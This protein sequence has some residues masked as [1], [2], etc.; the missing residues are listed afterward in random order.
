MITDP[1][2]N[3]KTV[4]SIDF[5]FLYVFLSYILIFSPSPHPTALSFCFYCVGDISITHICFS[6]PSKHIGKLIDWKG[7]DICSICVEIFWLTVQDSPA[8]SFP[9][10]VKNTCWERDAKST[11]QPWIAKQ[12]H[13]RQLLWQVTW[14]LNRLQ[15]SEK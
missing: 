10:A 8:F 3:H 4:Y 7:S 14:T 6:F 1:V 13:S 9:E 11:R 5:E 12:S 15:V 2:C